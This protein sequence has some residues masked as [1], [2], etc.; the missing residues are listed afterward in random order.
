MRTMSRIRDLA[1]A[2]LALLL[3]SG[4]GLADGFLSEP[5]SEMDKQ[6]TITMP[7]KNMDDFQSIADKMI[8]AMETH[9]RTLGVKGVIVVASMDETGFSWVSR[10]KAVKAMKD[11][12]EHPEQH[13]YPG[14]NFI[15]IAYSKAAEMADTKLNSGSKVRSAFQGEFGYPGGVIRKV[16]SGYIL[17]VFSGASGEQDLEIANVGMDAYQLDR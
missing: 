15:G 16:Q 4:R 10:M 14:Y 11:I 9:A 3:T 17:A 7:G 2:L 12:P 13:E 5:H 1:V 6:G 8:A